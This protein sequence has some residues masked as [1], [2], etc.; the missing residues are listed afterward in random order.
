MNNNT[1]VFLP[2]LSPY[3]PE[4]TYHSFGELG[5]AKS[6]GGSSVEVNTVYE[7][8]FYDQTP[9]YRLITLKTQYIVFPENFNKYAKLILESPYELPKEL[10]YERLT[11]SQF[12][13]L[14]QHHRN[15][16]AKAVDGLQIDFSNGETCTLKREYFLPE[17]QICTEFLQKQRD[18]I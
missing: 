10:E 16:V 11:E 18:Q 2:V 8:K 15:E 3:V 5:K 13:E 9:L 14:I 17:A 4:V 12:K 1:F 6:T 7:S